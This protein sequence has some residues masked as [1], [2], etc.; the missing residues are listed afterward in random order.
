MVEVV[1][2]SYTSTR[3]HQQAVKVMFHA[4]DFYLVHGST[5]ELV[6]KPVRAVKIYTDESERYELEK[7]EVL[8]GVIV[9][10][11]TPK[12]DEIHKTKMLVIIGEDL[13]VEDIIE[14]VQHLEEEEDLDLPPNCIIT[15]INEEMEFG[16]LQDLELKVVEAK[17]AVVKIERLPV[18]M[19]I[20]IMAKGAVYPSKELTEKYSLE[21]VDKGSEAVSNGL[22]IFKSSDFTLLP[23]NTPSFMLVAIVPSSLPK[24]DLFGATKYAE[25]G[26]PKASVLTQ[27]SNT[28][29]VKILEM[30]TEVYGYTMGEDVKFVD[31]E[32]IEAHPLKSQNNLYIIPKTVSRGEKQ[33]E[34]DYIKRENVLVMPLAIAEVVEST[35]EVDEVAEDMEQGI[36]AA[37][38]EEKIVAE[39]TVAPSEDNPFAQTE[40]AE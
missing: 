31:L 26:T 15:K 21:Y 1:D 37:A 35:E 29:G 40:A 13:E 7:G 20:R 39:G 14:C 28:Y 27:G 38:P 5:I 18:G 32:L 24:V 9:K 2:I 36:D 30:L 12:L 25:D 17:K 34:M 4:S 6:E 3:S 16:F 22:D 10:I 11:Y 33:G 19:K 8:D 23:E